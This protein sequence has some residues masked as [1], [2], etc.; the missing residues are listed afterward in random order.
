VLEAGAHQARWNSPGAAGVYF[1]RLSA[2][3]ETRVV[4]AIVTH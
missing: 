2:M 3:G 1:A 4:R